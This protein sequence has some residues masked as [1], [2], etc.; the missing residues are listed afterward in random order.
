MPDEG[1]YIPRKSYFSLVAL[2]SNSWPINYLLWYHYIITE[3]GFVV[4]LSHSVL[5]GTA[6]ASRSARTSRALEEQSA[7]KDAWK[8]VR[9]IIVIPKCVYLKRDRRRFHW[10][11]FSFF[12]NLIL[13]IVFVKML[14]MEISY[15][16]TLRLSKSTF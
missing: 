4:Q 13:K 1:D 5:V 8:D 12:L 16:Y 6:L 14:V 15:Y 7:K 3:F 9:N 2:R 10:R 11:T